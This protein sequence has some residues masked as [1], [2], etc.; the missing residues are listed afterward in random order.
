[1]FIVSDLVGSIFFVTVCVI[2]LFLRPMLFAGREMQIWEKQG[3]G[4]GSKRALTC[5]SSASC[6]HTDDYIPRMKTVLFLFSFLE[7]ACCKANACMC[8][9]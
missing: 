4:E 2:L 6:A 7:Y 1:M 5:L 8:V 9:Q 3:R